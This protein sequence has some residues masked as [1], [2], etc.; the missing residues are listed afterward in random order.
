M[1]KS[2]TG[3]DTEHIQVLDKAE[4]GARVRKK[5]KKLHMSKAALAEK[6]GS[7]VETISNIEGAHRGTSLNRLLRL[8]IALKTTPNYLLA[9]V[10]DEDNDN[11]EKAQVLRNIM[12]MLAECD[13]DELESIE[14]ILSPYIDEL[15]RMKK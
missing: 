8:A 13:V 15:R 3:N 5:R 6:I 11:S 1:K 7:S 14:R 12:D 10:N 9:V 4:L 2:N